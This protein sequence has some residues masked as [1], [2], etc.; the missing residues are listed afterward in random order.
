MLR[1]KSVAVA[2]GA[3]GLFVGCAISADNGSSSKMNLA[4]MAGAM[5]N[6][7]PSKAAATQPANKN[8]TGTVTFTQDGNDVKVVADITGLS[9]GKHGFH[10]HEKADMSDPQLKSVGGHWD[11]NHHKHGGPETAEHHSGDLGNLTADDTGK[12]HLEGK[13]MGV[14]LTDLEGKSVIVHASEDDLKT[15]PA[16]NSGGRVAGGAIEIKK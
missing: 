13:L 8:V 4:D 11:M 3:L 15:D 9:P 6:V 5:A 12:A 14:K 2:F 16:G 7:M 10:I 1:F